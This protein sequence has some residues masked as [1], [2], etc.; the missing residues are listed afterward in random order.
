MNTDERYSKTYKDEI[1]LS[2]YLH[3][4]WKRRVAILVV[5]LLCAIFAGV[6]S[7]L[8]P[9]SYQS[10]IFVKIG[11]LG[12]IGSNESEYR[13][14]ETQYRFKEIVYRNIEEVIVVTE[15]INSKPFLNTVINKNLKKG[16]KPL[17]PRELNV[18]ATSK[19]ISRLIKIKAEGRSPKEAVDIINAIANEVVL[20]HKEKTD[21]TM[22]IFKKMEEDLNVQIDVSENR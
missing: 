12:V 6:I 10:E 1:D 9:K 8:L 16:E 5:T 21:S 11:T 2:K 15:L 17:S 3:V 7:F 14:K 22:A 4:I 13:S 18:K 20:R 19:K